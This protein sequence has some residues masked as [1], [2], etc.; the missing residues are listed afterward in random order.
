MA[1]VA[2][3]LAGV[4]RSRWTIPLAGFL[5][6]LMGGISYAWGV[7]V[8][9]LQKEFGWTTTE[10]TLPFTVFMVVFALSMVP[11]GR[12]QDRLGPRRVAATGA[13]LFL[14]AYGLAYLV[15]FVPHP[16]WLVGT[17]GVLGGVACGLTYAC[18]APPARKWFP[19]RPG[20]AISLA[21][22]GFGLAAT[23]VAPLKARFLIPTWGVEG[24]L[25]FL[26]FLV[27]GVSLVAAAV[28][29]NPPK[30]WSPPGYDPTR[31]QNNRSTAVRAEVTPRQMFHHPEF[32]AIWGAFALVMIGGLMALKVIP[33]YGER[34]VG[35]DPGPAAL[36]TSLFA[37]FNG[38]GRPLAGYLGDRFGPVRVMLATYGLQTVVF[39][40]FPVLAVTQLPLY[41]ASALLGWGYAVTLALFP[42]VTAL[43][44][45]VKNLGANYGLVFTAFGA[46]ALGAALGPWLYDLTKSYSPAFLLAGATTGGSLL[47]TL[48]LRRKYRLP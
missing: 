32:Y 15:R 20:L 35:L 42:S 44:F 17:Y 4:V 26:G 12:F 16:M 8:L 33:S 37:L 31:A 14:L 24:T 38:V 39:L 21:V 30:G 36:A 10:A 34:V 18:V 28:V 47:L 41:V 19:D 46:G 1:K 9:P 23:I 5:L 2:L 25:L 29:R 13:V 27:A 45:G 3:P 43:S 40:T 22:A 7:F 48:A 6:A 11:G